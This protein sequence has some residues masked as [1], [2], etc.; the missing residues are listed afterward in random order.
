MQKLYDEVINIENIS[1]EDFGFNIEEIEISLEKQEYENDTSMESG[2]IND[3]NAKP[4]TSGSLLRW[5]RKTIPM[6]EDE[7]DC[8]NQALEDYQQR[9]GLSYGFVRDLLCNMSK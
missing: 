2:K 4:V 1:V 7:V 6:T 9:T 3:G 5:D 8:L